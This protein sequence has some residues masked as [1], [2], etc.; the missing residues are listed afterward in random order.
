MSSVPKRN[1]IYLLQEDERIFFADGDE[2]LKCANVMTDNDIHYLVNTE[3]LYKHLV[4]SGCANIAE[5]GAWF[6]PS[7]PGL[8]DSNVAGDVRPDGKKT[9]LFYA[10][11][12]NQRNLFYFGV[13]I[14]QAAILKGILDTDQWNIVF[15]GK[16]LSPVK[17]VGDFI[18]TLMPPFSC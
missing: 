8:N 4:H 3:L 7:F 10:R 13:E 2:R 1:V 9:F 17:L 6:E 5:K 15:V 14:I 18:P 11:P 16:D 12:H